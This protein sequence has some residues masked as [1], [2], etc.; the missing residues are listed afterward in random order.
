MSVPDRETAV[1]QLVRLAGERDMPSPEATQRARAAAL[2]SWRSA[3]ARQAGGTRRPAARWLALAAAAGIAGVAAT[4]YW[5]RPA[6]PVRVARVSAVDGHAALHA[7]QQIHS[8]STLETSGGRVALVF[9]DSLSLRVDRN[10]RLRFDSADSVTLLGGSVYVDSGGVNTVPRLRIATPAGEVRH[11][12]T[13]FQVS[14]GGTLAHVRA[15][16]EVREGRVV[17][18]RTDG[19]TQDIGA[20]DRLE[21]DGNDLK[22]QRGQ[23]AFGAAWEWVAQTAPL[24][25]MENRPLAEFLTWIAREHGWQVRYGDATLQTRAQ[26]IRLHGSLAGLD[27]AGMLESVALITGVPIVQADGVLWIG[28]AEAR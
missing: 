9:G 17:L 8:A 18:T 14:V 26:G 15:R 21:I 10:T 24:F 28:R 11:V 1:E 20:G 19:R 4:L 23:P 22:L 27:A 7:G 2:E 6:E 13:Q 12:G 5:S 16:V 3:L 25:D